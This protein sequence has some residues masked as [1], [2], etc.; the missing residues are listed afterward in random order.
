MN[1]PTLTADLRQRLQ[2][3]AAAA[4]EQGLGALVLIP[5]PDL[6][7]LTGYHAVPLERLTALVLPAAGDPVLIA[8]AL[9][10]AAALASPIAGLGVPVRTWQETED[11]YPLVADLLPRQGAIGV[12][13]HMW[14]EQLLRL[15]AATPGR[16]QRLAGDVLGPLRMVKSEVEIAALR[17]AGAAIDEVHAAM[18]DWLR[19]G[20][21]ESAVAADI[22]DA[23]RGAGHA[24]VDFVIVGSGPNGASPHHEVSDRVIAPGE[25]VVVD[26]GGS[27][28][29]GYCSDATR[30]YCVGEPPPAFGP[31]YR[32]LQ[33]AQQ[34]AVQHVRP[35]VTC[36]SVDAV[37]RDALTAAG[38]GE[39]FIHRTGHG[40]GLQTH[41]E[42]Y[43]VA[44]NAVPLQ[45]GMAFSV[46]P[47]VYLPGRYG[48]RIEDIVVCGPDGPD[49]LNR[50]PRELAVLD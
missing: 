9:E 10:E 41:E 32:A 44:G 49:L 31:A 3:A 24:T 34:A 12:D 8:P 33:Q 20:R 36:A 19:A 13:N 18:G 38:L 39:A 48:A 46:E 40:I 2:R 17:R 6:R 1:Q 22:A 5:G 30:V 15:G 47:G 37:A 23:I 26:I 42:P 35:G 25:P 28:P 43:I 14:A 45:P 16:E 11:P 29:D 50:R 21:T 4:E 7:Y 27:M